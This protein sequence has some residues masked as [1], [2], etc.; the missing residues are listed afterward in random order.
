[1][2]LGSDSLPVKANI[3]GDEVY[4][5]DSMQFHLEYAL[6]LADREMTR[7]TYYVSSSFRGED[8]DESHLNQFYHVE[9]ELVGDMD[10]A[11]AVAEGYVAHVT[12]SLLESHR[13]AIVAAAGKVLHVE[14]LLEQMK[15]PLP[16]ITHREAEKL[17]EVLQLFPQC[18]CAA[19][20]T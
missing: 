17:F 19:L 10:E 12:S 8:H 15:T 7:G 3:L 16:R 5:A 9:C 13:D 20:P 18:V 14:V 2:G 4:L 1:M 11:I 6:R